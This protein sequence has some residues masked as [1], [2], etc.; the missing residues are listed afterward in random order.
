LDSSLHA[1]CIVPRVNFKEKYYQTFALIKDH[2]DDGQIIVRLLAEAQL[3]LDR[4]CLRVFLT[5]RPEVPNRDVFGQVT[6][7]RHKN[8]MLHDILPLIIDQDIQ[9]F[10]KTELQ[11]IGRRFLSHADWPNALTI[12]QLVQSAG[13]LFTWAATTCRFIRGGKHFVARRLEMI[14]R[15]DSNTT[16]AL[17]KHLDQI[18]QPGTLVH[19][20]H[21]ELYRHVTLGHMIPLLVEYICIHRNV[22]ATRI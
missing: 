22:W 9:L 19:T 4:V 10:L 17:R 20:V 2:V 5:S 1:N 7:A 14:I 18:C 8:F 21:C 16:A 3:L 15:N 6:D 11:F 12:T 13:G